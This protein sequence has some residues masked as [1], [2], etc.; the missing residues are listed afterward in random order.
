MLNTTMT[1]LIASTALWALGKEIVYRHLCFQYT[2]RKDLEDELAIKGF[3]GIDIGM[4]KL[5][6]LMY[7][8]DMVIFFL[9]LLKI[10]K[11]G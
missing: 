2:L 8:D 9:I 4:L 6:L 5:Y 7:A 11:M 10:Y 1:Q 3:E